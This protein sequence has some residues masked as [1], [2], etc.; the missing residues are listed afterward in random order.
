MSKNKVI[1]KI[2]QWAKLQWANGNNKK[3]QDSKIR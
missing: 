2:N 3:G 1:L